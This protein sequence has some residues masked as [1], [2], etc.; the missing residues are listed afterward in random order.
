MGYA[1]LNRC[2]RNKTILDAPVKVRAVSIYLAEEWTLGNKF[3]PPTR[4]EKCMEGTKGL[5][6]PRFAT[7]EEFEKWYANIK[8]SDYTV[9]YV[10]R[11]DKNS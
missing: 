3:I 7:Y 11:K 1:R 4:K 9:I 6:C 2:P 10:P 8:P 5:V